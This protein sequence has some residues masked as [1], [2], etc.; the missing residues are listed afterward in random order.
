MDIYTTVELADRLE[1]IAE[2]HTGTDKG[3]L[4][5]A[6]HFL[7]LYGAIEQIYRKKLGGEFYEIGETVNHLFSKS[8]TG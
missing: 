6:A 4:L 2:K 7:R 8:H 1:E 5:S 3:L